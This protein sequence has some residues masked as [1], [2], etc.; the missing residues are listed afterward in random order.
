M[1][2]PVKLAGIYHDFSAEDSSEDWGTEIDLVAT[3]VYN[4]NWSFQLK[5]ASF[6]SDSDAFTD[7]DKAWMTVNF[8]I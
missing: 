1:L 2:G 4:K 8:K 7:T 5:Y 6:S 3:W